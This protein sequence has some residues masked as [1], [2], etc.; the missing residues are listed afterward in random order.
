MVIHLKYSNTDQSKFV[1]KSVFDK[2]H[3]DTVH[4]YCKASHSILVEIFSSDSKYWS[5]D[6]K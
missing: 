3:K 1:A 6:M 5:T 2:S 4:I